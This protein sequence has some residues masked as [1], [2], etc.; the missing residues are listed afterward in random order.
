MENEYNT[1]RLKKE[2]IW[3]HKKS[4]NY[5]RV[6]G[7]N[8]KNNRIEWWSEGCPGYAYGFHSSQSIDDFLKN[9]P[10][11]SDVPEHIQNEITAVIGKIKRK[12][13]VK[14]IKI[15]AMH[16]LHNAYHGLTIKEWS[17][18]LKN[19]YPEENDEVFQNI[20]ADII[21]K[22]AEVQRLEDSKRGT[23]Y[24]LIELLL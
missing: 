6:N 4:K 10:G 16:F 17:L 12:Q 18:K 21:K 7:A 11:L 22:N 3:G 15:S 24:T 2:W 13:L 1:A 23:V 19:K 20:I 8:I 5:E 14:K 9:G